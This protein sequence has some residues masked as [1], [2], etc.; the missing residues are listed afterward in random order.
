MKQER[1]HTNNSEG[2][3]RV[4]RFLHWFMAIWMLVLLAVGFYMVNLPAG[5]FRFQT[6]YPIHKAAGFFF[7]WFVIFR[8]V[9][10]LTH[11]VP[12]YPQLHRLHLFLTKASVP[13]LYAIMLMMPVSGFV[14]SYAGGYPISFGP[15]G[16]LPTVLPQD[17]QLAEWASQVHEIGGLYRSLYTERAYF[18]SFLSSFCAEK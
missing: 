6:L 5:P 2:F 8:L 13:V 18:G 3:G 16:T 1:T 17:P 9:W 12:P 10:R 11:A 14:A 4:S 15:L 7:L